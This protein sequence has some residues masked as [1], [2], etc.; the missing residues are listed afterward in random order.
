MN[1]HIHIFI[2]VQYNERP[3]QPRKKW[4]QKYSNPF[5]SLIIVSLKFFR[6]IFPVYLNDLLYNF[7]R[8]F[9][10]LNIYFMNLY[11]CMLLLYIGLFKS[12]LYFNCTIL[13]QFA[14]GF[15]YQKWLTFV[16]KNVC[17]FFYQHLADYRGR[18]QNINVLN[19]IAFA[20]FFLLLIYCC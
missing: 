2:F 7:R 4:K 13:W 5:I 18:R 10:H 3:K 17:T 6:Y 19:F 8:N 11:I 16:Y 9:K 15:S 14:Y 1:Q 12:L 20:G